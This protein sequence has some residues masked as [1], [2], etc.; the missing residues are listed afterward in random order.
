M[1]IF[2][3]QPAFWVGLIVTLVAGALSTLVGEG[4]ISDALAGDINDGLAAIAQLVILLSPLIAGLLI[5][6]Q[7]TPVVSPA[8]PAGTAVTVTNPD[9]MVADKTVHL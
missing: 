7:V 6:P 3:R 4:V 8:L 1:V 5:R 2:G 9:P